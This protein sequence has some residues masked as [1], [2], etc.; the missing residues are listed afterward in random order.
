MSME[1]YESS[2]GELELH[3]KLAEVEAHIKNGEEV[4]K[5]LKKKHGKECK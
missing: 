1:T 4:F 5:D 3:Q 2:L